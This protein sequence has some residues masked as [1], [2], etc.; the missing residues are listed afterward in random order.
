M[1]IPKFLEDLNIIAR[2]GNKPGT[3]DG[4]SDEGFKAKFD[5]GILKIQNYINNVLIPGIEDSVS[6]DGLLAQI[7]DKLAE[8]LSLDGGTMR[9]PLNM[10]Y[11]ILSGIETPFAK[12]HAANKEYVD[13]KRITATVSL[14]STGWATTTG[15]APYTQTVPVAAVLASDTPHWGVAYSDSDSLRKAEKEAFALVDDMETDDGS[16]T[17]TCFEERPE[18]DLTIQMEVNR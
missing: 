5:E 11:K 13:G 6:E 1:A 18:T 16:V 3:D 2:L 9:G 14:K 4:L 7:S 10:D 12:D 17:F 8:K 15:E